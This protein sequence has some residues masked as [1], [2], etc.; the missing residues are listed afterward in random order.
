[1]QQFLSSQTMGMHPGRASIESC[2]KTERNILHTSHKR[3][4][5]FYP[6]WGYMVVAA[7]GYNLLYL[8]RDLF[9]S[10]T[11]HVGMKDFVRDAINIPGSNGFCV[12]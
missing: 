4:R 5:E 11:C 10:S 12:R 2:I 6:S 3:S 8:L 1:M 7:I 9:F